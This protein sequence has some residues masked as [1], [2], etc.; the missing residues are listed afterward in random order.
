MFEKIGQSAEK[1]A[2]R[3]SVSRRG[4]IGRA[5]KLAAGVGAALAALAAFPTAAGAAGRSCRYVCTDGTKV[6]I[7][8]SK[9]MPSCPF[10]TT[11]PRTGANCTLTRG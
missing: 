2:S 1:V 3:V 10:M 8:L 6:T 9:W 5:A 4:F 11:N 7:L